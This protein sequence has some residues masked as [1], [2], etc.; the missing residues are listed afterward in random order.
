MLLKAWTLENLLLNKFWLEERHGRGHG[1]T[2]LAPGDLLSLF[3]H[4][5]QW[6]GPPIS[7]TNK[8]I[9]WRLA[10][11]PTWGKQFLNLGS[12][13]S[14]NSSFW[15]GGKHQTRNRTHTRKKQIHPN[16]NTKWIRMFSSREKWDPMKCP[17]TNGGDMPT[18]DDEL[19]PLLNIQEAYRPI[20]EECST[21]KIEETRATSQGNLPECQEC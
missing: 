20:T 6:S 17:V 9:L 3:S 8:K 4:T 5:P 13:F 21:W 2:L 14:D 19:F 16:I 10:Y 15:Q 18:N 1:G 12:L 7:T 11:R